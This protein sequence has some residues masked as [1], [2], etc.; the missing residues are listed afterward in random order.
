MSFE[1]KKLVKSIAPT[2]ATGLG[3]TMAGLAKKA[4]TGALLGEENATDDLKIAEQAVMAA[5][6]DALLKLKEA[7]N[8]FKLEMERLGV[9]LE[10]IH[11]KD[12][13]SARTLAKANMWPQ[14]V[15]SA[16]MICGYFMIIFMEANDPELHI[17]DYLIGV[18]TGAIPMILQFWFGS[19]TGSKEKTN[20]IK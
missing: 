12:R 8:N 16:I 18:L 1:R 19:S 4:I 3:G 17:D 20:K 2:L 7:D 11:A 6:P 15:L 5:N 13:D 9:E 10:E 14:I